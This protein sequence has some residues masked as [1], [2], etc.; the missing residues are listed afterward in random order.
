MSMDNHIFLFPLNSKMNCMY[1]FSIN[2]QV[3]LSKNLH[4]KISTSI[5][6]LLKPINK[7][8]MIFAS[9]NKGDR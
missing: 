5:E 9:H 8:K 7:P 6:N 3:D 4:P 1:S 2:A